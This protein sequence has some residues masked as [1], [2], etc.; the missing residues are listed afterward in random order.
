MPEMFF[1]VIL[2]FLDTAKYKSISAKTVAVI[3]AEKL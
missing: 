3:C 2:L 1:E